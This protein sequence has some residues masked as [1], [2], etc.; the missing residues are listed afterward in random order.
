M[1]VE[2]IKDLL[3][4]VID[5]AGTVP[6]VLALAGVEEGLADAVCMQAAKLGWEHVGEGDLI[7]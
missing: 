6:E 1:P 3:G 2:A 7:P 5:S 4:D